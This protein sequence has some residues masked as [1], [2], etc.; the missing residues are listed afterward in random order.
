MLLLGDW[1]MGKTSLLKFYKKIAQ[2]KGYSA[3]YCALARV[4]GKDSVKDILLALVEEICYGLG[5]EVIFKFSPKYRSNMGLFLKDCLEK[6]YE[7]INKPVLILLDDVQNISDKPQVL[8]I[9]RLALSNEELIRDTSYLFVL[10][11]TPFGWEGF[12]NKHDPIGRFFRKKQLLS[13][14]SYEDVEFTIKQ[15]LEGTG[16]KFREEVIVRCWEFTEGHPYELQLLASHLYDNH[17]KGIVDM[18]CW[19]PAL[20][21]SLR[22]LGIEYFSS[23]YNKASER[24]KELLHI[25]AEKRGYLSIAEVRQILIYEKKVRNYPIANVKNFIYRL[26]DKGLLLRDDEGRYRI[27]DMMFAEFIK[28]FKE[29][30]S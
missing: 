10:S 13:K 1:G 30:K 8:D 11:S 16:V 14:L 24:E 2:G 6:I 20:L 3:V 23:L 4:S 5:M 21:A 27:L 15:T 9:I 28:R 22:D 29:A 7:E 18:S 17:K 12:L 19:E 26:R 25:F